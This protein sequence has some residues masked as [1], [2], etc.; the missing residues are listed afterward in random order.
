M[1]AIAPADRKGSVG[2]VWVVQENA[3]WRGVWTRRGTSDTFDAISGDNLDTERGP[4]AVN[5]LQVDIST[6]EMEIRNGRILVRRKFPHVVCIYEGQ[7]AADGLSA[8]GTCIS[9]SCCRK[10][11]CAS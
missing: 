4:Q 2:R 3:N 5:G 7:L 11:S 9:S 6:A 1:P 8:A 10:S